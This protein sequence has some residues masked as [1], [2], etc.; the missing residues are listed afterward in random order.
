MSSTC[1]PSA[2][3]VTIGIPAWTKAQK[4]DAT[5]EP[6]TFVKALWDVSLLNPLSPNYDHKSTLKFWEEHTGREKPIYE[7]FVKEI[8]NPAFERAQLVD[9]N[10]TIFPFM[11]EIWNE[12]FLNSLSRNYDLE[13]ALIFTK[14]RN[15]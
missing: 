5:L 7:H 11:N 8:G 12:S 9:S 10:V 14:Y 4:V 13:R 15:N 3:F 1:P 6:I 2:F